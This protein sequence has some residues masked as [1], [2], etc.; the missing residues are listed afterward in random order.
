MNF[1]KNVLYDHHHS[2]IVSKNDL[3]STHYYFMR[4]GSFETQLYLLFFELKTKTHALV[5]S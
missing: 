3:M 4:F 5:V 2:E 1:V